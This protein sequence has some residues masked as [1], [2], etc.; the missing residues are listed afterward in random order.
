MITGRGRDRVISNR[1][2]GFEANKNVHHNSAVESFLLI[3]SIKLTR[4]IDFSQQS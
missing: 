2:F 4:I 1:Q 3:E